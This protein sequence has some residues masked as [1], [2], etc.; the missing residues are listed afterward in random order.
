MKEKKQNKASKMP[1][2]KNYYEKDGIIFQKVTVSL[3]WTLVKEIKK[4]AIDVGMSLSG[5]VEKLI[6]Q[7]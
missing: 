1:N 5:Y 6:R 3:P 4:E 7:R 2:K